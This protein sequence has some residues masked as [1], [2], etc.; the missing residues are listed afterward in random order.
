[1]C[2]GTELKNKIKTKICTKIYIVVFF[3]LKMDL[4]KF[5][6]KKSVIRIGIKVKISYQNQIE[7]F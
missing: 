6:I 7:K 5:G 1:V 3:V 2:K 4:K